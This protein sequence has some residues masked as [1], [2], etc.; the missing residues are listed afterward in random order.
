MLNSAPLM[1]EELVVPYA[2]SPY[3]KGQLVA[4][5]KELKTI[6]EDILKP[7]RKYVLQLVEKRK[8]PKKDSKVFLI[9]VDFETDLPTSAALADDGSI[10]VNW[11]AVAG[12]NRYEVYA[13]EDLTILIGKSNS[14]ELS[15]PIS[16]GK[17]FQDFYVRP[18]RGDL[19][20]K[21]LLHIALDQS[22]VKAERVSSTNADGRYTVGSV[23]EFVVDFT[24]VVTVFGDT[25]LPLIT[26]GGTRTA[27][28]VSDGG[29]K[30]L[31]FRYT[32]KAGDVSIK[33]KTAA[34]LVGAYSDK[35][36]LS[37]PGAL[38]LI[39]TGTSLEEL[40]ALAIDTKAPTAPFS[41]GFNSNLVASGNFDLSWGAGTDR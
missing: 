34:V 14:N 18:M 28:Y 5:E 16:Q 10:R 20:S 33:L 41:V 31:L 2:D 24:D 21:D 3:Q 9:Q 37:V 17:L 15:I 1:T 22:S 35:S 11:T 25:S 8:V 39:G 23:L 4:T 32:V 7:D 13:D 38:P 29:S 36:G 40:K 19:G 27:D 26:E 6:V 12:A 30:S